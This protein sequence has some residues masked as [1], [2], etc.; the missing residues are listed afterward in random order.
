M[1][2]IKTAL[3]LRQYPK[4]VITIGIRES[5]TLTRTEQRTPT[6]NVEQHILH[7]VSMF[8]PQNKD[9]FGILKITWT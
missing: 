2:E 3:L 9:V 7:F 5:M 6:E 4:T 1:G 8:N